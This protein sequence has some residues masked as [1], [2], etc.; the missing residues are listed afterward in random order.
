MEHASATALHAQDASYDAG[1]HRIRAWMVGTALAA[2]L[3]AVAQPASVRPQSS[4]VTA[5]G[6]PGTRRVVIDDESSRIEELHVRGEGQ[7]VVV[8]PKRVNLPPWEIRPESPGRGTSG[9]TRLPR[10]TANTR[11]WRVL[12]F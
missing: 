10:D 3:T 4:T 6:E 1:L 2:A 7:R 11:M 9:E 12:A 5:A 8:Q